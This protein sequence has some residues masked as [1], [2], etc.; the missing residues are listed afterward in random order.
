MGGENSAPKPE[1]IMLSSHRPSIEYFNG[2]LIKCNHR[3]YC[4]LYVT[5]RKCSMLHAQPRTVRP[6]VR[7]RFSKLP[8]L[9]FK[10]HSCVV[11]HICYFHFKRDA[12]S[13]STRIVDDLVP[14]LPYV[15]SA[16]SSPMRHDL[17]RSTCK[18]NGSHSQMPTRLVISF[19]KVGDSGNG[20]GNGMPCIWKFSDASS[21]CAAIPFQPMSFD[22][23]PLN[24]ALARH[25]HQMDAPFQGVR[26]TNLG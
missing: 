20:N 9:C 5:A 25:L 7:L 24:L 10:Y 11:C 26:Y 18:G 15:F 8:S 21:H 3:G 6:T 22:S 1:R 19:E 17:S 4:S 16:P 14:S 23:L 13:V 2:W 12:R